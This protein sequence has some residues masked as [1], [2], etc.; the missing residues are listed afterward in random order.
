MKGRLLIWLILVTCGHAFAQDQHSPTPMPAPVQPQASVPLPPVHYISTDLVYD[1]ESIPTV[2]YERFFVRKG[3]LRSWRVGVA[4]QVHYSNQFGIVT[5]HGDKISVGVYQGP[6]A[7]LGYSFYKRHNRK[8]WMNYL[9][10]GLDI[11]YLWYD[12]IKVNTGKRLMDES[13]RIQSEHCMAEVP[14]LIVGAKHTN[15]HFCADFYAGLQFPIKQR[16]KTI[17][18]DV[19]NNGFA[20]PNVPYTSDHMLFAVAPVLGIKLGYIK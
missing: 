5:S 20:N 9:S 8:H 7:Q 6:V 12:D 18:T 3:K 14:Q 13:Y 16:D 10:P 2:S 15:K 4:Y 11:K 19:N 1:I 17:Y